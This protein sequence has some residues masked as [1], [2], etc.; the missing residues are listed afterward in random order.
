MNA[1]TAGILSVFVV[2]MFCAGVAMTM[3]NVSAAERDVAE[4]VHYGWLTASEAE[5]VPQYVVQVGKPVFANERR[6]VATLVGVYLAN[7]TQ[8]IARLDGTWVT[9]DYR[10]PV[11]KRDFMELASGNLAVIQIVRQISAENLP[12]W[13]K[14][15]AENEKGNNVSSFLVFYSGG[16]RIY[17]ND[18]TFEAAEVLSAEM[19]RR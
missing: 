8:W 9:V 14:E 2:A 4:P 13:F 12:A 16:L 18:Q 6:G 5:S 15:L 11:S 19:N 7:A 17:L 1:R 10:I 3:A